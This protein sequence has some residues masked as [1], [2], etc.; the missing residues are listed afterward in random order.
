MDLEEA[1]IH[2]A[3]RGVRALHVRKREGLVRGPGAARHA[4]HAFHVF[5]VIRVPVGAR[6][7]LAHLEA[8]TQD[9]AP[10]AR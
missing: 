3:Q 2:S 5:G 6:E 10:Q 7:A 9:T 4:F 1:G 8:D